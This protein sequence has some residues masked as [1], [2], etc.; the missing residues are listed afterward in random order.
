[1]RRMKQTNI[2]SLDSFI[3]KS[4][5]LYEKGGYKLGEGYF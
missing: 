2:N 4:F 3:A 1:M 5:V